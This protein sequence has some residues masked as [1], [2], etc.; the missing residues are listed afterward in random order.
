MAATNRDL[1]QASQA[2]EFRQIGTTDEGA[3]RD[4]A[5]GWAKDDIES[6]ARHFVRKHSERVK[7]PVEGISP[8]ALECL[9]R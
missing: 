4:A 8:K 5:A 3:D 7:R 6:L 2:K 1:A 9:R